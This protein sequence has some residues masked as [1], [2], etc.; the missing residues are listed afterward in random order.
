M[1]I[2]NKK[3]TRLITTLILCAHSLPML[4]GM[5]VLIKPKA[6]LHNYTGITKNT[7]AFS[8]EGSSLFYPSII[9]FEFPHAHVKHLIQSV[10]IPFAKTKKLTVET[11]APYRTETLAT[12][13][14]DTQGAHAI[15]CC[16]D[17]SRLAAS[18]NNGTIRLFS[19]SEASQ[20]NCVV[21][22]GHTDFYNTATFSPNST[23][24][25]AISKIGNVC[26]W[27][28]TDR[29]DQGEDCTELA[30]EK[31][32]L[33]RALSFS[34]DGK[35]FAY[36]TQS[37]IICVFSILDN[38]VQQD[39]LI[40]ING[41]TDM[42]SVITFSPDSSLLAATTK[43]NTICLWPITDGTVQKDAIRTLPGHTDVIRQITF[44]PDGT[45]LASASDDGTMRLWSLINTTAPQQQE[46]R[47][48]LRTDSQ[49]TSI[50]TL[51]FNHD[52]S[53]LAAALSGGQIYV[54]SK[55]HGQLQED[56]CTIL[57]GHTDCVH[58]L[59]FS[60]DGTT[61]ASASHDGTICLWPIVEAPESSTSQAESS[62]SSQSKSPE[63]PRCFICCQESTSEEPL[64]KI[65]CGSVDENNTWIRHAGDMHEHC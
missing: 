32:G 50:R 41:N 38:K 59:S 26:V 18:S 39:S 22:S 45:V 43:N 33:T 7:I 42:S 65:P 49:H 57:N 51:T 10:H 54:W 27:S 52:G 31:V 25:A 58:A 53:L 23:L 21:L 48:L 56:R 29:G 24:L 1:N 64:K 14:E 16:H 44:S 28:I 35:L 40:A 12:L 3:A 6:I 4:G 63:I 30:G 19:A 17:G 47:V 62:S 13:A 46:S 11:G 9:R 60:P 36:A 5:L 2:Q 8:P 34:P 37:G 15:T 55:A 20:E 61:L